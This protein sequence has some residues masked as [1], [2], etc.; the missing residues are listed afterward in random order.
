MATEQLFKCICNSTQSGEICQTCG[1]PRATTA[2]ISRTGPALPLIIMAGMGGVFALQYYQI[3][4][5]IGKQL[6]A[7]VSEA[8]E[9]SPTHEIQPVSEPMEPPMTGTKP[10]PIPVP[11]TVSETAPNP[12]PMP[13]PVSEPTPLPQPEATANPGSKPDESGTKPKPKEKTDPVS[14][15]ERLSP[16]LS[17]YSSEL[18][19]KKTNHILHLLVGKYADGESLSSM[20]TRTV[21][22]LTLNLETESKAIIDSMDRFMADYPVRVVKLTS[23]GTLGKRLEINTRRIFVDTNGERL[24][25]YGKT[26]VILDSSHR[27]TCLSDDLQEDPTSLSKG[28]KPIKYSLKQTISNKK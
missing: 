4:E 23:V 5:Q 10:E 11:P 7:L 19:E 15:M 8:R 9:I 22:N 16:N 24:D 26:T 14:E 1:L 6:S 28:F 25:L 13:T 20:F 18:L 3:P 12:L 2:Y 17:N 21:V 27:I